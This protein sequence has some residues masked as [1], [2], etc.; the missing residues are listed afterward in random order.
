MVSLCLMIFVE[1]RE[2]GQRLDMYV[3]DRGADLCVNFVIFACI[4]VTSPPLPFSLLLEQIVKRFWDQTA[5]ISY[6]FNDIQL[7]S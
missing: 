7:S 5:R 2:E 1:G 4:C 6:I 3:G